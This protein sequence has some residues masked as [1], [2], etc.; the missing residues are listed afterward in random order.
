MVLFGRKR[1]WWEDYPQFH[2]RWH[3]PYWDRYPQPHERWRNPSWDRYRR[4]YQR[5][6][7]RYRD[8]YP[9]SHKRN[10]KRSLPWVLGDCLIRLVTFTVLCALGL[11]WVK[12]HF[13]N[14]MF[15]SSF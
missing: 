14:G 12:F 7:N 10:R 1:K 13:L 8:R 6:R 15:P 3:N 5:R 11:A 9:W 2:E 4:P